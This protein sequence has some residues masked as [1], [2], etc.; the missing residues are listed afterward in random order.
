MTHKPIYSRAV[1]G[2]RLDF[3]Y[4]ASGRPM[5]KVHRNGIE[6]CRVYRF[7]TNNVFRFGWTE[8]PATFRP[9]EV[10][11]VE[12][13]FARWLELEEGKCDSRR[14][15]RAGPEHEGFGESASI[16]MTRPHMGGRHT[17]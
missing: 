16:E 11:E 4:T 3:A 14:D 12:A 6:V 9:S 17:F 5:V 1:E 13:T 8:N 10:R 2:M 15:L 7:S